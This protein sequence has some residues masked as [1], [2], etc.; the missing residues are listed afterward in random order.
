[1][2]IFIYELSIFLTK[3]FLSNALQCICTEL[4]EN[5]LFADILVELDLGLEDF[6]EVF[7]QN[8][9]VEVAFHVALVLAKVDAHCLLLDKSVDGLRHGNYWLD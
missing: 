8:L 3:D 9:V 4:P 6:L 1:M 2:K 7:Y 5:R